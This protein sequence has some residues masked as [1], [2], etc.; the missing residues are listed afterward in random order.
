MIRRALPFLAL[1]SV[2]ASMNMT[3]RAQSKGDQALLD[4]LVRKGVLT[5]KEADEISAEAAKGTEARR[6][7]PTPEPGRPT[8][9]DDSVKSKRR[10]GGSGSTS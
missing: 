2:L 10:S 1:V 7:P 5:E 9:T 4:A 8:H 3:A 6:R